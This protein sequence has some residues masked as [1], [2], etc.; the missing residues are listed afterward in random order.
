MATTNEQYRDIN[1]NIVPVYIDYKYVSRY[2]RY[3]RLQYPRRRT[4]TITTY[5]FNNGSGLFQIQYRGTGY[6][7][8]SGE[9]IDL[10]GLSICPSVTIGSNTNIDLTITERIIVSN[11]QSASLITIVSDDTYTWDIEAISPAIP[12]HNIPVPSEYGSY[13]IIDG[14]YY[15]WP[16]NDVD[17]SGTFSHMVQ[18]LTIASSNAQYQPP[19]WSVNWSSGG[20]VG[21]DTPVYFLGPNSVPPAGEPNNRLTINYSTHKFWGGEIM[22]G[23]G[24]DSG[25]YTIYLPTVSQTS[26]FSSWLWSGN[27][28][29]TIKKLF[30][31]PMQAIIG[32]MGYYF[33]ITGEHTDTIRVGS[34]DSEITC[35]W[36]DDNIKT[37]SCG[38]VT[39]NE[40]FH[41]VL[42]YDG[43][44][45]IEIY[46]PYIGFK[47]LNTAE[48]MGG[49]ISVTY[50][51]DIVTGTCV[52]NV[53]ITKDNVTIT[54]YTFNGDCA[55]H[56][57]VSGSDHTAIVGSIL[58]SVTGIGAVVG[59]VLTGNPVLAIGGGV[60]AL[61][62]AAGAKT[63]VERAGSLAGN[64]GILAYNKP[65]LVIT[66]PVTAQATNF[67]QYYGF[68]TNQLVLLSNCSGYTRVKD[69]HLTNIP[70]TDEE[71]EEIEKLLKR[72]VII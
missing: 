26:Q 9:P 46:L 66:R 62:S 45:Q 70:C 63:K 57:P 37:L 19:G 52:A 29:D 38:S 47:T 61:S 30:N 69:C 2:K 41:N 8:I 58:G 10:I 6:D 60:G 59:G 49:T 3:N 68:P 71:L 54:T 20:N 11:E 7:S 67:E 1:G 13:F 15:Y 72:G 28:F 35:D 64:T 43:Y 21:S 50:K 18:D 39:V 5:E 23:A 31:D 25:F 44:T 22:T 34:L 16:P 40:Q 27:I 42:D 53:S 51:I 36:T 55:I 56:I 24:A 12:S 17:D 33:P 4:E 14:E 48:V 65:Y 32:L